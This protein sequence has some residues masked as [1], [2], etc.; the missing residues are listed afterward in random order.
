MSGN[1]L[2]YTIYL[3]TAKEEMK[4]YIQFNPQEFN[5]IE[6]K[7]TPQNIGEFKMQ[8]EG[9]EVA[10]NDVLYDIVAKKGNGNIIILS[11]LKDVNETNVIDTYNK[12]IVKQNKQ[13][14]NSKSAEQHRFSNQIYDDVSFTLALHHPSYF[15]FCAQ[16]AFKKVLCYHVLAEVI[17]PPPQLY[18]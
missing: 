16:L 4:Q 6:F 18:V 17:T 2:L 7:L 14:S 1:W 15:I 13:S 11:C 3:H 9:S 10:Y 8:D 12:N 5:V